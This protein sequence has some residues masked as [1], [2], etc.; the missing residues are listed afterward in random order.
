M[1]Y[2]YSLAHLTVQP[3]TPPEMVK[4][5]IKTGY[6]YVSL[7]M[8]SLAAHDLVYPLMDNREM[9]RETKRIMA[10]TGIRVH[11]IEIVCI[12][13]ATEPE[14]YTPFFEAGG[15]L[16]A[17]SVITLI[18]DPNCNRATERFSRLCELAEPYGLNLDL[19]FVADSPL[20]QV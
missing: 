3:C 13:P 11:D 20:D 8:K 14:T 6:Q 2:E 17:R 4:I 7:R 5:A 12:D 1:A 19:E 10:D 9:M 16:N 15:E 18:T